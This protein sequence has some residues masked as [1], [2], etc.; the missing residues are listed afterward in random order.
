MIS[1]ADFSDVGSEMHLP[2]D[3]V[4]VRLG[5]RD[6]LWTV[7]AHFIPVVLGLQTICVTGENLKFGGGSVSRKNDSPG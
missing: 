1:W 2:V 4:A 6:L 3:L 7:H 5:R